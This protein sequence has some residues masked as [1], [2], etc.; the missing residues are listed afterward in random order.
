M[1]RGAGGIPV[2]GRPAFLA[3]RQNHFVSPVAVQNNDFHTLH[4]CLPVEQYGLLDRLKLHS[5]GH[6]HHPFTMRAKV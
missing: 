4:M 5:R 2:R 6:F 3:K 1:N